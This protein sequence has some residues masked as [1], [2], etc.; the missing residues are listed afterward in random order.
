MWNDHPKVFAQAV[1]LL[2]AHAAGIRDSAQLK[3]LF[4]AKVAAVAK[5]KVA[6]VKAKDTVRDQVADMENQVVN[7]L[8][9]LPAINT[10]E[11]LKVPGASASDQESALEATLLPILQRFG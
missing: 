8:P 7:L 2:F 5:T 11:I 4:K 9:L 10:K 6:A 3:K 1:N